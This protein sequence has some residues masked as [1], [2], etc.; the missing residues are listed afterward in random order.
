MG[1]FSEIIKK[2]KKKKKDESRRKVR[3]SI[4]AFLMQVVYCDRMSYSDLD[5]T[6]AFAINTN[7]ANVLNS[8]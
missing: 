4:K 8:K 7:C 1:V 3:L 6:Y 2:G 5:C